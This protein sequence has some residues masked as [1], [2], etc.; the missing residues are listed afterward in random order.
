MDTVQKIDC[1]LSYLQ[2]LI[3]AGDSLPDKD[4]ATVALATVALVAAKHKK[5]K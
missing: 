1:L 3:L 5:K 4:S 2:Y